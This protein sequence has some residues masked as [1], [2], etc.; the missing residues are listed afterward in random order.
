M[1]KRVEDSIDIMQ[2]SRSSLITEFYTTARVDVGKSSEQ[3]EFENKANESV[4]GDD[5]ERSFEV[6]FGDG[7][8]DE[9][10]PPRQA[11]GRRYCEAAHRCDD[12][13]AGEIHLTPSRGKRTVASQ[14]RGCTCSSSTCW[15]SSSDDRLHVM[16]NSA[17]ETHG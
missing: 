17:E 4:G 5:K 14:D 10:P 6:M 12:S 11:S 2:F 15:S 1:R 8:G 9:I 16:K 3:R 13:I 7:Q